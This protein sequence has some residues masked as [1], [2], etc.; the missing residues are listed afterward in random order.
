MYAPNR[1]WSNCQGLR[2]FSVHCLCCRCLSTEYLVVTT[3]LRSCLGI[4]NR[5]KIFWAERDAMWVYGIPRD[6][7][8][9]LVAQLGK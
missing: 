6:R 5:D 9:R 3:V 8:G 2:L 7:I 1:L 4:Y